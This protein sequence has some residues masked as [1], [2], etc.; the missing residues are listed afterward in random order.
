VCLAPKLFAGRIS[1]VEAQARALE[2]NADLRSAQAGVEAA[3]AQTQTARE[4][5]NPTLALSTSGIATDGRGNG[6]PLHNEFLQRSYDSIVS[7]NQLLE[8]AGKRSLRRESAEAGQ[9]VAEAQRD[10]ARRWLLQSVTQ[11][12]VAALVAREDVGILGNSAASLRR[13]ADVAALRLKTGDISATD[14]DQIEMAADRFALDADTARHTATVATI[15]LETL[16]GEAAPTGETE[17]TD[18]LEDLAAAAPRVTTSDTI[19]GERP[20][21]VAAEANV[22]KAEA[23]LR[24]QQRARIPDLTVSAQFEHH[25]PDQPNTAGLGF[26]VPLP[27]WNRNR[28]AIQAA[29]AARAQAEAQMDRTR[30]QAAA[31][32]ATA[33]SALRD[34]EA[35]AAAF[36]QQMLPKSAAVL[37]AITY[38]YEKGGASLLD[39]LSAQR[40]DNDIRQAAAHATADAANARVALASALNRF[41]APHQP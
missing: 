37:R 5:P 36:H 4:F 22:R 32:I 23:E 6:S 17:L 12:Y 25:P 40:N 8:T 16:V 10:E 3:L 9:R 15:L 30:I 21:L 2:R 13:E 18:T 41:S 27:L 38:A 14:K 26:S 11:A 1:L 31:E 28:G 39:L 35:R 19:A 34:A 7:L 20:D 24:L 33:R 29:R